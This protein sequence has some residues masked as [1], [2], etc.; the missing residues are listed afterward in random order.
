MAPPPPSWRP[1]SSVVGAAEGT[2]SQ[3]HGM[4]VQERRSSPGNAL[5][6]IKHG[7][8]PALLV[9]SFVSWQGMVGLARMDKGSGVPWGKGMHTM[10]QV[11]SA[12]FFL[13]SLL[14]LPLRSFCKPRRL[15]P[16]TTSASVTKSSREKITSRRMNLGSGAMLVF[17]FFLF[18][19]CVFVCIMTR[20][21]SLDTWLPLNLVQCLQQQQ[22][23]Q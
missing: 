9:Q 6:S 15:T 2:P 23:Q 11:V 19:V 3:K 22:Q 16:R 5:S 4:A 17:S 18:C 8:G 10:G 7:S 21:V 14:F 12:W 13:S 20:F 1:S